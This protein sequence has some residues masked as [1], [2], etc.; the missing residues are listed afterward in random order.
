M[1]TAVAVNAVVN[2]ATC[3]AGRRYRVSV[4]GGEGVCIRCDATD[5]TVANEPWRDGQKFEFTCLVA[6]ANTVRAIK[7]VAG[8]A[9]LTVIVTALNGGTV[10]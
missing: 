8:T 5:P 3:Q 2:I 4:E 9:N 10:V 6:D 1:S 7:R